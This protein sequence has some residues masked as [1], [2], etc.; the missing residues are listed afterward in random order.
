MNDGDILF[1][2]VLL[3]RI[4]KWLFGGG[5]FWKFFFCAGGEGGGF[6]TQLFLDDISEAGNKYFGANL[7]LLN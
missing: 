2:V 5:E 7:G 6:G 4:L 1:A 3:I